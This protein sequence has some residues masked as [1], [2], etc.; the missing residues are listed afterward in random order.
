VPSTQTQCELV[1]KER[2]IRGPIG[3]S[4]W[5]EN[6]IF[7]FVPTKL[8]SLYG[9]TAATP[10]ARSEALRLLAEVLLNRTK[11]FVFF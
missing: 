8:P 2:Q 10:V 11:K 3:F 7:H 4:R 1:S 6:D 5:R 9:V